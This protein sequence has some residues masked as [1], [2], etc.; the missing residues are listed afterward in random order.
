MAEDTETLADSGVLMKGVMTTTAAAGAIAQKRVDTGAGFKSET[1]DCFTHTDILSFG[2]F[3]VG[4]GSIRQHVSERLNLERFRSHFGVGPKAIVKVLNAS[5]EKRVCRTR[6]DGIVL[7][8][9]V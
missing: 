8:K 3:L 6:Y 5:Q 1:S 2:L 9:I 7:A 4:F